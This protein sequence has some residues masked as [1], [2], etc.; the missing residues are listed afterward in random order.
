MSWYF[1][2]RPL[3]FEHGVLVQY[4]EILSPLADTHVRLSNLQ[5][6]TQKLHHY[7]QYSLLLLQSKI[8]HLES[9]TVY[10]SI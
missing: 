9:I 7:D 3:G 8:P 6:I 1:D 5:Q 4:D 10:G 2:R